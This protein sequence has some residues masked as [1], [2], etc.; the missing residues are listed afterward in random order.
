MVNWSNLLDAKIIELTR[1]LP[2]TPLW[3]LA[4]LQGVALIMVLVLLAKAFL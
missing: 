4:A 2:V 1:K 3:L